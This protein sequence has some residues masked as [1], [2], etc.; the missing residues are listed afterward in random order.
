MCQALTLS[1]RN[2]SVNRKDKIYLCGFYILVGKSDNKHKLYCMLENDECYRKY[3]IV[4][5]I[6][7]SWEVRGGGGQ[8]GPY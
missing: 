1:I 7:S 2:I 3:V 5:G 6:R 8:G 4:K